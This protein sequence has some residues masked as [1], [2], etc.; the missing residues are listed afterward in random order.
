MDQFPLLT[1][2]LQAAKRAMDL[3]QEYMANEFD[4][5]IDQFFFTGASKVKTNTASVYRYRPTYS[6]LLLYV[7]VTSR[8]TTSYK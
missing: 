8:L 3:I 5:N 7:R 1:G 4:Y 6:T 2:Q